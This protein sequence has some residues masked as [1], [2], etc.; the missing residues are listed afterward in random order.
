MNDALDSAIDKVLQAQ[1]PAT[2]QQSPVVPRK[3][4]ALNRAINKVIDEEADKTELVP[5]ILPSPLVSVESPY[6]WRPPLAPDVELEQPDGLELLEQDL[7]ARAQLLLDLADRPDKDLAILEIARKTGAQETVVRENYDALMKSTEAA[8]RDPRKWRKENPKLWQVFLV[9]P[10]LAAG[11]LRDKKVSVIT[12][13]FQKLSQ[14]VE[15]AEMSQAVQVGG[16]P[17]DALPEAVDRFL[18]PLPPEKAQYIPSPKRGVDAYLETFSRSFLRGELSRL[19]ASQLFLDARERDAI[20]SG[21]PERI[22]AA[23]REALENRLKMQRLRDNIGPERDYGQG[24]FEQ[25]L[26]DASEM[27]GTQVGALASAG[28]AAGVAGLAGSTVGALRGPPGAAA[29]WGKWAAGLAAKVFGGGYS[30]ITEAGGLYPELLE[31]TTYD[32]ILGTTTPM[33]P[34][35]AMGWSMIYGI[36]AGGVEAMTVAPML[37]AFGF[38]DGMTRAETKAAFKA[39]MNHPGKAA[40]LRQMGKIVATKIAPDAAKSGG[41]EVLEEIT[42]AILSHASTWGAKTTSAGAVQDFQ[43]DDLV[44]QLPETAGKA[45]AGSGAMG[46]VQVAVRTSA[47]AVRVR[48]SIR[49]GVRLAAAAKLSKTEAASTAP[50]QMAKFIEAVTADNEGKPLTHIYVDPMKLQEMAMS[51]GESLDAIATELLGEDGAGRLRNAL[52]DRVDAPGMRNTLE[53]PIADFVRSWAPRPFVEQMVGDLAANP[54]ELTINELRTNRPEVEADAA[55]LAEG[56]RAEMEEP[57]QEEAAFV[58]EMERQAVKAGIGVDDARTQLAPYRSAIRTL[59]Q[60]MGVPAGDLF[61]HYTTQL[62][63]AMSTENVETEALRQPAA[64]DQLAPA[65][66]EIARQDFEAMAPEQRVRRYYTD[67]NT[68]LLNLRGMEA[69]PRDPSRPFLAEWDLEGSKFLNDR[70][71]HEALDGAYRAMA[72]VLS[73]SG[74]KD[75]GKVGGSIRAWVRDQAHAEEIAAAMREAVDPRLNVTTA[76]APDAG[77]IKDTI[78]E[79]SKAHR[80]RKEELGAQRVIGHRLGAPAAFM[81]DTRIAFEE[82]QEGIPADSPEAIALF[83]A[84]AAELAPTAERVR[85]AQP[86]TDTLLSAEHEQA[87]AE[88]QNAFQTVYREASGLLTADGWERARALNPKAFVMSADLRA[89]RE[90]NEAFGKEGTD[91]LNQLFGEYLHKL[92]AGEFDTAHPH[93]DEYAAQHDDEARLRSFFEGVRKVTDRL[94]FF[95][96]RED[97]SASLQEGLSFAYGTA[98]DIDRADRVELPRAKAEQDRQSGIRTPRKFRKDERGEYDRLV[99]SYRSKPDYRLV[100]VRELVGEQD[101]RRVEEKRLQAL[102]ERLSRLAAMTPEQRAVALRKDTPESAALAEVTSEAMPEGAE[103]LKQDAVERLN[104]SPVQEEG[105]AESE[106]A[107]WYSAVERAVTNAKQAKNTPQAWLAMLQKTPGVRAEEIEWLGL[108]EWLEGQK[109]SVSREQIQAFIAENRIEV[110]EDVQGSEL[111]RHLADQV[112]AAWDERSPAAGI[113]WDEELVWEDEDGESQSVTYSQDTDFD[114]WESKY[115]AAEEELSE[116]QSEIEEVQSDLEDSDE[117]DDT[118]ELRERLKELQGREE[119]ARKK[120][121]Q[122]PPPREIR[123]AREAVDLAQD[124]AEKAEAIG[125]EAYEKFRAGDY[126]EAARLARNAEN[127]ESEYDASTPAWGEFARRMRALAENGDPGTYHEYALGGHEPGSYREILFY[128]PGTPAD[129]YQSSH[130]DDKGKGLLAHARISEHKTADGK[131]ILFVEEIQSDLHQEGRD[132]G[133]DRRSK[134]KA[135]EVEKV[136][137][138]HKEAKGTLSRHLATADFDGFYLGR[139]LDLVF[140]KETTTEGITERIAAIESMDAESLPRDRRFDVDLPHWSEKA[141]FYKRLYD[142]VVRRDD[143]AKTKDLLL[144]VFETEQNARAVAGRRVKDQPVAPNA[145]FKSTWDEL[146]AKRIIMWAAENGYD[147]VAW[148]TGDQQAARYNLARQVREIRWNP[149]TKIA[150]GIGL[151]GREAFRQAVEREALPGA[152][153]HEPTRRLLESPLGA[154]GETAGFHSISGDDLAVGGAGMRMAYDQRIPSVFKALTKKHG[155]RVGKTKLQAG[156]EVWSVTVPESL[157][158]QVKTEGMTLFQDGAKAKRPRGFVEIARKGVQSAFKIFITEKADFSTLVHE[159]AHVYFEMLGDLAEMESAPQQVKDDYATLLGWVGAESSKAMTVEQKE[160]LARGFERYLAEGKAPSSRLVEV[161]ETFRLWMRSI[162]RSLRALNVEL[163]DEVR[164]VFDRMLATDAEIERM[165]AIAGVDRPAFKTADEAGMTQEEFDAYLKE[166]DKSLRGT[167]LR[168]HRAVAEARLRAAKAFQTS[169]FR[170][171]EE[172][173]GREFDQR[174]DWRAWRYLRA[175]ELRTD[176]GDLIGSEAL[177]KLDIKRTR[178]VLGK[179]H[180]ML[181]RLVGRLVKSGGEDPADVA[182]RMGYPDARS[183]FDAIE[184]MP[185][186]AQSVQA[187]AEEMMRERHPE[188]DGEIA[189][190]AKLIQEAIHQEG[191]SE[192][193]VREWAALGRR[194]GT[195]TTLN[196]IKEAAKTVVDGYRVGRLDPGVVLNR[197]RT[198]ADKAAMAIAKGEWNR[199]LLFKTKQLMAHHQ[200]REL[201]QAVKDRDALTDLAGKLAKDNYRK[202]L[203]KAHKAYLDVVD[204][205]LEN[206]GF[207][208]ERETEEARLGVDAL[209]PIMQGNLD[210][211]AFDVDLLRSLTTQPKAWRDLTVAE[212]REVT[213]ALNNIRKS[214]RNTNLV[215]MDGRRIDREQVVAQLVQEASRGDAAKAPPSNP[216]VASLIEKGLSAGASIDGANLRPETMLEFLGVGGIDSSWYRAIVKPLQH[217]KHKRSELLEKAVKP[218]TEA[219]D[220]APM[221]VKKRFLER[222]DGRKLFPSHTDRVAPPMTRVELII[223]AANRGTESNLKR[224]TEGRNITVEQVDAAIALLTPDELALVRAMNET[225][226]AL[227]EES[228][229]LE[230]R[231]QGLPP[232]KVEATPYEVVTQGGERVLMPGGYFPLVGDPRFSKAG[233]MQVEGAVSALMDPSYTKAPGTSRS[234]LKKRDDNAKYIVSLDHTHIQ[235][236]IVQEVNDLAYREAVR[237]V[238]RLLLDPDVEAVMQSRLGIERWKQFLPWLKDIVN[239]EAAADIQGGALAQ[240]ARNVKSAAPV[241]ILGYAWDNFAADPTAVMTNIIGSG[242]SKKH[243]AAALFSY[244]SDRKKIRAFALEN[245]GEMRTRASQVHQGFQNQVKSMVKS[246]SLPAR[247]ERWFVEHAFDMA[248]KIEEVTSTPAWY[249]AYRQ[250]LTEG[251]A[252]KDAVEFADMMVRRLTPAKDMMDKSGLQR[253]KGIVGF[254]TMFS[255]YATWVYNTDRRILSNAFSDEATKGDVVKAAMSHL[256]LMTVVGPLAE[257]IVGRGPEPDDGDDEDERWATW[258]ARKLLVAHLMPIPLLGGA[259]EGVVLGK[260]SSSRD[261]LFAWFETMGKA[262]G[263]V[264]DLA[265]GDENASVQDAAL[266]IFKAVGFTRGVPA[267]RP[268]RAANYL[269]NAASG[270]AQNTSPLGVASG[271]LYGEREGQGENPLALIEGALE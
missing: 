84:A 184:Q 268:A 57:S 200:W 15:V 163:N 40:F 32:E 71:G 171:L 98:Q 125:Q 238:G 21:D 248:E 216:H 202:R 48:S 159:T 89:F 46:S 185:D 265:S 261:A 203:G 77:T 217:A 199:A 214:A 39:A 247:A 209:T 60:R 68:G 232:Q 154:E 220:K 24:E 256:A 201:T 107:R 198:M 100:G 228:R 158:E 219:F 2:T 36:M 14:L 259:L 79:S 161:F 141:L 99:A 22:E 47:E 150:V 252:H 221:K 169:E 109:G 188:I 80:A 183:M 140:G 181:K 58:E 237:S 165:R 172:E 19:G 134:E 1:A 168:A 246:W 62:Q 156:H 43:L 146:V 103:H 173:A 271:I 264:R 106:R 6:E 186:R 143:W 119:E 175:G 66:L 262:I 195:N 231:D 251:R 28:F 206:L 102:R 176:D 23:R 174:Q 147:E 164:G 152:F 189:D 142:K 16:A 177:G 130:F 257:L 207:V 93:G 26:L 210:E 55:V 85:Q 53:V 139:L 70:H 215:I 227:W 3:S 5:L 7:D 192:S 111:T 194:V 224:L 4:D 128:A 34:E 250:A 121:R 64:P 35:A 94:V 263:E 255:G 124:F 42:Q 87:F 151:D 45:L 132:K 52:I 166:R 270:E 229:A 116:I 240:F 239:M 82:D 144:A 133:Y 179:G 190:L 37:K 222:V 135:A 129:S 10:L 126:E 153:G 90:M 101:A 205:L 91:A 25:I 108:K 104:Q 123:W 218:F 145:P 61:R 30:A 213:I 73:A 74:I 160:K 245:S 112:Q 243:Y 76:I 241:A 113:S 97:G 242:L 114:E 136:R 204:A 182:E 193:M 41:A 65:S 115:D 56:E 92:G 197:E 235:R 157:R 233:R 17:M 86:V 187:R 31:T 225:A 54:G 178:E 266:K 20:K 191:S 226:S 236:H 137:Q 8:S 29:K 234:R 67:L 78:E 27:A 122:L 196:A 18:S 148:T 211:V 253:S 105:A 267:L 83:D 13:A 110:K 49:N 223:M 11:S 208:P 249:G 38:A 167:T 155:G 212:A 258:F 95:M 118:T 50:E 260:P 12:K 9:D 244:A 120:L 162:Y 69:S 75:G 254:L 230:E 180:P 63:R 269:L 59:S 72:Q 131:P 170:R 51:A 88:D 81:G 33:D 44:A 149:E 117:D 96:E 127:L 138:Q